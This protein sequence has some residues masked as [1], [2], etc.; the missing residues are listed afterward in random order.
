MGKRPQKWGESIGKS[1]RLPVEML[2]RR[3][4]APRPASHLRGR[5]PRPGGRHRHGPETRG[6]RRREHHGPLRPARRRGGRRPTSCTSPTRGAGP[7][8]TPRLMMC[9]TGVSSAWQ[10]NHP[11][12]ERETAF[13]HPTCRAYRPVMLPSQVH[14]DVTDDVARRHGCGV[15]V[16]KRASSLVPSI[17]DRPLALNPGGPRKVVRITCDRGH[18]LEP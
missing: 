1:P 13:R 14:A 5:P 11:S 10:E 17:G 6:P 4:L 12:G 15:G 8:P 16:H 7:E 2:F 9:D 3:P 18:Y